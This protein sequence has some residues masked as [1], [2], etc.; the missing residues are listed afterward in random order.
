[1]VTTLNSETDEITLKLSNVELTDVKTLDEM[2]SHFSSNNYW[3]YCKP[4]TLSDSFGPYKEFVRVGREKQLQE[5]WRQILRSNREKTSKNEVLFFHGSPG[6]GKTYLL[7]EL[8]SKKDTDYPLE[9]ATE[10]QELKILVLDFNRSA[11]IEA[12]VFK[13]DLI[14]NPS[15]FALSRLYYVTFAIQAELSWEDFLQLVVVTLIRKGSAASLKKFMTQQIKSITLNRRS[16]ILVD[17]IMKTGEIGP[18]F[19]D[20]VRSSVCKWIDDGICDVILFSSLDFEFLRMEVTASGRRVQAVTTLPLLEFS[21]SVALLTSSVKVRFVDDEGNIIDSQAVFGQL[22]L[23][24]GGHPRSLEYIVDRCNACC[25]AALKTCI[26]TVISEAAA[27]LCSAYHDVDNWQRIFVLVLLARKVKKDARLWGENSETLRSLVARGILID[28]FDND[29][30]TFVPAV[31]EL[32]LHKWIKKRGENCLPDEPRQYLDQI[33]RLR[34]CFTALKFEVLHSSW[35]KLMRHIRQFEPEC[36]KRIPLNDLY[37][38]QLR[39]GATFASSCC[40]DSCSIL[41]EI[42]YVKGTTITLEPNTIYN[43]GDAHNPGW[44]RLIVMEAFPFRKSS[45]RFIIP[46]FIQ[47]KF[48]SEDAS[49]TLSVSDV[50]AA[51]RHCLDFISCRVNSARPYRFLS[52]KNNWLSTASRLSETDFILLFVAKRNSNQNT[53]TNSPSNVMFCLYPELEKLYGPTLTGFV[54]N[55]TAGKAVSVVAKQN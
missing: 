52:A 45:K 20:H 35:E 27:T 5:L 25:D 46:V 12:K 15:L 19:A 40:V 29:S 6:L 50:N 38:C 39:V 14:S 11:C 51:H 8:F 47:N 23:T 9:N 21:E 16:L 2:K 33:L 30:D 44:D 42:K 17:E 48:S 13:S 53:I 34:S 41:T 55:L 43:P 4:T 26:T 24:S 7:R 10:V 49:S 28:S 54:R 32:C 37:R 1:M 18:E 22:A 3:S 36:Y 31:P